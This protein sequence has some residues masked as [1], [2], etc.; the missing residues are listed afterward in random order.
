VQRLTENVRM[1]SRWIFAALALVAGCEGN[2]EGEVPMSVSPATSATGSFNGERAFAHLEAICALGPRVSGTPAMKDQRQML[3]EH[4]R[5]LGAEVQLQDFQATHPLDG[6]TMTMT[7]M[8]VCWHPESRE[9]VL[10]CTHFDTRPFPDRDPLDPRGEFLGANDGAS[11]VALLMELGEH[12]ARLDCKYGI[13]FVF[14]DGEELVYS[15]RFDPYFLGSK[16]FARNYVNSD[17]GFRYKY[18]VLLDMVGDAELQ[19]Y[20]EKNSFQ[21]ARPLT[22]GIWDAARRAGVKEFV[23]RVR[24]EVRDDH[25]PLNDVADIETCDVIDFDFPRPGVRHSYWHT[26]ADTPQNCSAESLAKVGRVMIE[27]L[28]SVE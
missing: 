28:K 24:H 12:V 22:A 25:L 1:P 6:A 14:F 8:I 7:N 16:H 3:A 15:E 19:V 9:R 5:G 17:G 23:P 20:L 4:F 13:D 26:R 27:W 10:L 11:G 2:P 21:K 18:G